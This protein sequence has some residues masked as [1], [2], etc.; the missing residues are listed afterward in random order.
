VVRS[1]NADGL[2]LAARLRRASVLV[3]AMGIGACTGGRLSFTPSPYERYASVLRNAGLSET[4]LGV[5]WLA[6]GELSLRDAVPITSPFAE[7]G[8]FAADEP[9]AVAYRLDLQ[10]GRRLALEVVFD[11]RE[12][13]RLFVDL[14]RTEGDGV[15][16]RV[17]SLESGERQLDYAVDRN[18]TYVVRVQPELLQSGRF[19]LTERTLA[20]LRTFPVQGLTSRALQSGFGAQR[21]NGA[22]SHEGVDIFAPRGTPVV[23]V[24]N[25][26]ASPDTNGLGGNVVWLRTGRLGGTRYYYAHLDRWAIGGTTRVEEGDLL[27]YVGNTGNARGT[28]PHLHFGVYDDGPLDP[29]PFVAADEGPPAIPDDAGL[30]DTLVRIRAARVPL[31]AGPTAASPQRALLDQNTIAQRR[32]V[33]GGWHRIA[34]PD[35]TVGY[36]AA[37]AITA[38]DAPLQRR[39]TTEAFAL[40]EKPLSTAPVITTVAAG[41]ETALLGRF[42]RFAYVRP[43]YG[44]PGWTEDSR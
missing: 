2:M 18:A 6:V 5:K 44:R 13:G 9:A 10:R 28:S 37:S 4:A 11:T 42:Q 40:R 15:F 33:S 41:T 21:D 12:G 39:R 14:F 20:G 24:T 36:V 34:L 27:G 8:Y 7:S 17:A 32:G 19:V 23:A 1:V 25:G 3:I 35:D 30:L 29:A 26:V 22:R 43:L 38:A 16:K 31:R